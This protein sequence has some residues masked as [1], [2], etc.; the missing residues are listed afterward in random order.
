VVKIEL[1]AVLHGF[2]MH[3]WP[4]THQAHLTAICGSSSWLFCRSNLPI[5]VTR[6]SFLSL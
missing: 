3:D 4:R 6:G 1:L 5:H 2:V